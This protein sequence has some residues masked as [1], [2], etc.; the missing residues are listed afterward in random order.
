MLLLV[1]FM[2]SPPSHPSENQTT[3]ISS[4]LRRD[5]TEG[6]EGGSC[7]GDARTAPIQTRRHVERLWRSKASCQTT[8]GVL[9][10]T[11][12]VYQAAPHFPTSLLHCQ[13]LVPSQIPQVGHLLASRFQRHVTPTAF[14]S[15]PEGALLAQS[16]PNFGHLPHLDFNRRLVLLREH[17]VE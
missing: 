9:G 14:L 4:I 10:I 16:L 17:Q 11:Y 7:L 6:V 12:Q 2:L 5:G 8:R 13:G 15:A 3:M 1:R